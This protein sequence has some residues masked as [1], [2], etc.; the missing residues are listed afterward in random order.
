ME[1]RITNQKLYINH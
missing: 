1:D